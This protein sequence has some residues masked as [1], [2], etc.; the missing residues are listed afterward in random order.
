MVVVVKVGGVVVVGMKTSRDRRVNE[1]ITASHVVALAHAQ[2]L[3][4][5]MILI[6]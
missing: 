6:A 3:H 4:H 2:H 5:C 1:V